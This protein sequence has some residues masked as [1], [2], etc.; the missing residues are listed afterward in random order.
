MEDDAQRKRD[1]ELK[2]KELQRLKEEE[3]AQRKKEA[4]KKRELER[5]NHLEE[6]KIEI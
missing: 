2:K 4:L 1:A 6:E 3:E 5:L